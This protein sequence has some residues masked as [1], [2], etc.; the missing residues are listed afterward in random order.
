VADPPD[1]PLFV[2]AVDGTEA[3]RRALAEAVRQGKQLGAELALVMVVVPVSVAQPGPM[4]R[5]MDGMRAEMEM[6]A[7][8]TVHDAAQRVKALGLRA[9]TRVLSGNRR[10][11]V[12]PALAG[13]AA[14]HGATMIFVGTNDRN[15]AAREHLG[16]VAES[17]K[18]VATCPVCIVR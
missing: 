2:V 15:A 10:E 14:N 13:Y 6:A 3:S 18:R 8:D 4:R 9:R 5:N 1:G 16:S 7:A 12:G 17:L 11:D